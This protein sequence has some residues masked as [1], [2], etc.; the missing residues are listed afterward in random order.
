MKSILLHGVDI[1]NGLVSFK[2]WEIIVKFNVSSMLTAVLISLSSAASAIPVLNFEGSQDG[3]LI[4]NFYNGGTDSLGNRG[5]D[6]GVT[7]E[8]GVIR[9]ENGLTYLTGVTKISV[10]GGFADGVS[11]NYSTRQPPG[12]HY[13][14]GDFSAD[15]WSTQNNVNGTQFLGNT[16]TGY[17]ETL[18]GQFCLFVGARIQEIGTVLAGF[19]FE[20]NAAIDTINFGNLTAPA[21]QWALGA[22][23]P[24]YQVPEPGTLA[25][26]GLGLLGLVSGRS[27]RST[28][29]DQA[30]QARA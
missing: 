8:G 7:F 9:V 19:T 4:Q 16:G 28:S 13:G 17:C 21:T 29:E 15:Y 20:P 24:G 27:R 6:Y 3:A 12:N 5:G 10:A 18:P 22:D 23:I 14:D 25:L 30:S 1:A 11:F 2:S 26:V